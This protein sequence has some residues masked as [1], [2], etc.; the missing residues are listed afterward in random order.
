M[1]VEQK[2]IINGLIAGLLL[3]LFPPFLYNLRKA[4]HHQGLP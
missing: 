2:W 3:L 1:S 4:I